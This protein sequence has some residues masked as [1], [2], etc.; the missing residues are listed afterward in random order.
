MLNLRAESQ[1]AIDRALVFFERAIAL[2]PD[3]ARAHM[4]LGATLDLKGDYLSTPELSERALVSLDRAL[5][6]RPDWA[7]IW[8]YRGGAFTTL[9]RAD[10]ALA[11]FE[12]ALGLN[13]M[14]ASAHSGI[15]RVHFI[16]RGDF[17]RAVPSYERALALNPRAG[18]SA[19]QLA[20]CAT[21]AARLRE[22]RG[23]R[24]PR[25]RAAAGLR[26]GARRAW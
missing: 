6:L 17:A 3:Y 8:R 13:P 9:G 19:L 7:E 4:M 11:A 24:A 16:L 12:M 20:H 18:W 21:L 25:G 22:G 23:R 1:E 2:D 14:D 10:E 5:A 26:L 15:G